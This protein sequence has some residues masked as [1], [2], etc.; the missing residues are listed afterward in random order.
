M[1]LETRSAVHVWQLDL[2]C[3]A[4]DAYAA[5]LSEDEQARADRYSTERLRRDF[6][7]ARCGLRLVLAQ[8]SGQAPADIVFR[9][10]KFGKPDIDWPTAGFERHFNLSHSERRALIAIAAYPVGVDLEYILHGDSEIDALVDIVCHPCEKRA[11]ALCAPAQRAMFFYRIWS[12]KEAY[13]K[14]LGVGLQGRLDNFSVELGPAL[15]ITLVHDDA[16]TQASSY[17][18]YLLVLDHAE[19][20]YSASVCLPIPDATI[21]L[22]SWVPPG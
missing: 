6:M 5:I 15:P 1:Y 21:S 10:G 3:A 7:R 19:H 8:Y 2:D 4:L 12:R 17:Y 13:C 9:Y 14:A 20:A 22:R 16:L 11:F 18:S